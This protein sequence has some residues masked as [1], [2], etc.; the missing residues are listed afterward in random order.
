MNFLK[1]NKKLKLLFLII[2]LTFSANLAGFAATN[3][4]DAKHSVH[5]SSKIK[6][7]KEHHGPGLFD[8]NWGIFVSQTINFFLILLILKKY[9]FK[10]IAKVLEERQKNIGKIKLLAEEEHEKALAFKKEYEAHME[11]IE[12]ELYDLRQ[13]AIHEANLKTKEILEE[14]KVRAEEIIEKGEMELF[15]ERQSAWAN[16]REEV[17]ELTMIAAEKVIEEALDDRLH[18]NLIQDTITKLE[19]EMPDHKP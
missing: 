12:Q 15:M 9:A 11:N 8:I 17:V 4:H 2:V 10:P 6:A 14:A 16:I 19:K 5:E 1:G 7:E 3:Q 13:K 18:R